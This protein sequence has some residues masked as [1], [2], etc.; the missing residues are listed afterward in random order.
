MRVG[1]GEGGRDGSRQERTQAIAR[2]RAQVVRSPFYPGPGTGYYPHQFTSLYPEVFTTLE[3]TYFGLFI[4]QLAVNGVESTH[5]ALSRF[6]SYF[7]DAEPP[8]PPKISTYN[9]YYRP[10]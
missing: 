2:N 8:P 9:P 5:P 3:C 6:V 7:I 4:T 1:G 10:S